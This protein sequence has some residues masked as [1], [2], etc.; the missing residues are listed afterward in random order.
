MFDT[1]GVQPL[2]GV[3]NTKTQSWQRDA[4]GCVVIFGKDQV[5]GWFGDDKD[6]EIK[7]LF[8]CSKEALIDTRLPILQQKWAARR[9]Q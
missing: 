2:Y 6:V 4:T 7:E 8:I 1:G 3:W 9:N 5:S